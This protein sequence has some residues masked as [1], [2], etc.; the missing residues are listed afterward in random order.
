VE[1]KKLGPGITQGRA[2]NSPELMEKL[3]GFRVFSEL[4]E[5]V[6]IQH[7]IDFMVPLEFQVGCEILSEG[8][9]DE[10]LYLLMSGRV[11]VFKTTESGDPFKVV[12]LDGA[13]C[14]YFGEGAILDAHPRSATITTVEPTMCLALSK[15]SFDDFC[16]EY[17]QWGLPLLRYIARQTA[18]RLRK[19][20]N[21]YVFLYHAYVREIRGS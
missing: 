14:A 17:P 11:E 9:V 5:D 3:R 13:M 4:K 10:Y 6:A 15:Q 1:A 8:K 20:G 2:H 16:R 21:D 18:Q 7:L 12:E 19:I